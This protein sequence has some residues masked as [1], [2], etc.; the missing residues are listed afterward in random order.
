MCLKNI[1]I[2]CKWTIRSDR[3]KNTRLEALNLIRNRKGKVPH[4]VAITVEPTSVRISSL[5]LGTGVIKH[6][7]ISD[8]RNSFHLS[9]YFKI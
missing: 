4:I 2:S 3:A 8:I 6:T 7:K 9:R 5:A 1:Y